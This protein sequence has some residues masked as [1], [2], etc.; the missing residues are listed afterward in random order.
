MYFCKSYYAEST[1]EKNL[2]LRKVL[3]KKIIGWIAN[4]MD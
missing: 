4:R 1:G 2:S 3:I